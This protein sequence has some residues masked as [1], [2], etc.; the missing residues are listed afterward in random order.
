MLKVRD[1]IT[2]EKFSSIADA[3]VY[4][5]HLLAEAKFL[6]RNTIVSTYKTKKQSVTCVLVVSP[7]AHLVYS[8]HTII[9]DLSTDKSKEVKHD[10]D[11]IAETAK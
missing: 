11:P 1:Q 3:A 5:A 7:V 6:S 10:S 2:E 4:T 8:Q 9:V